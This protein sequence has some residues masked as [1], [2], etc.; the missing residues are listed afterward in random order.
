MWAGSWAGDR[1]SKGYLGKSDY[2]WGSPGRKVQKEPPRV[3]QEETVGPPVVPEPVTAMRRVQCDLR[4]GL[5]CD[6]PIHSPWPGAAPPRI[7]ASGST[8]RQLW[9][10]STEV[11]I[12]GYS[13]LCRWR[14]TRLILRATMA[15]KKI[16]LIQGIVSFDRPVMMT[17]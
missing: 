17:V 3:S 6:P 13:A 12:L 4:L 9:F 8:Q 11:G 7:L 16:H 5:P 2:E 14:L 15:S 1:L 10:Q